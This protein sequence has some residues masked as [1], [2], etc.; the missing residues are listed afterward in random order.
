MEKVVRFTI[1]L[2]INPSCI[3]GISRLDTNPTEGNLQK[4]YIPSNLPTNIL[5]LVSYLKEHKVWSYIEFLKHH[6]DVVISSTPV[7]DDW[8]VLDGAWFRRFKGA[9]KELSPDNYAKK[10]APGPLPIRLQGY[11]IGCLSEP[12]HCDL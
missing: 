3:D 2:Y 12:H 1:D 11:S 9:A 5:A 6:R 10:G 4:N 7:S 8:A